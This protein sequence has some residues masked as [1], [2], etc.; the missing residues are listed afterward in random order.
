MEEALKKQ[1]TVKI[2]DVGCGEGQAL[3]ELKEKFGKQVKVCGID[4][5]PAK[6]S[7][8][9]MVVGDALKKEWPKGCDLIISF[10]ALHEIGNPEKVLEKAEKALIIGGKA[11]L[12]FRA[13]E[14]NEGKLSWQGEMNKEALEFLRQVLREG[15]FWKA[16]ISGKENVIYMEGFFGSP[17]EGEKPETVKYTDGIT[18]V[19]EKTV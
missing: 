3:A 6:A 1:K 2:L 13:M 15:K 5:L 19:M 4:L 9:E 7:L 11:I 18:I 14:F 16:K 10:R 8:D 17:H 12:L